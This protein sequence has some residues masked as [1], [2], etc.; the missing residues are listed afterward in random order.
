MSLV[1]NKYELM[2]EIG[3]GKFGVVYKAVDIQ[4]KKV[5]AVKFDFSKVGLLR[6]EATI[7]NY[8][9]SNKCGNIPLIYWYGLYGNN[10][11]PCI[12]IPFYEHSLLQHILLKKVNTNEVN[13]L[14]NK[15]LKILL[16]IHNLYVIHRD[17]KPDNFMLSDNNDLILI[18]FGI[19]SFCLSDNKVKKST[20]FT[21]NLIYASPS[22][23]NLNNSKAI[24]D[25]ISLS[26]VYIFM[27]CDGK[28]HWT[29]LDETTNVSDSKIEQIVNEKK[30]ENLE[31]NLLSNG[32]VDKKIIPFLRNLYDNVV[33]YN[34]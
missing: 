24:D 18:D 33:C 16:S 13:I 6:H 4:C 31:L 10:S 27:C 11:I 22:V 17:I 28:L 5:V 30:I 26:Y 7:L 29:N 20:Q 25:I 12:V 2:S 15:M 1:R 19:S 21:G 9:K 3:K 34:F 32:K 23:H 8:L 14:F